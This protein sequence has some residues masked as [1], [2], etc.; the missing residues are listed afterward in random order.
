MDIFRIPRQ[1]EF[2][3]QALKSVE[4]HMTR[5]DPRRNVTPADLG[6]KTTVNTCSKDKNEK[7]FFPP[8]LLT[9]KVFNRNLQNY[10]IDSGESSN[11]MPLTI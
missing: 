6:N 10:L 3:L 2:L 8:F 9:V 7:T 1:K 11:V 4:N 5:N